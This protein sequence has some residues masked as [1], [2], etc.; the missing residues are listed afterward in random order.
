ML[1]RTQKDQP[2]RRPAQAGFLSPPPAAI[3]ET[4]VRFAWPA[5][6]RRRFR[7]KM[8]QNLA[9]RQV[10]PQRPTMRSPGDAVEK[11]PVVDLRLASGPTWVRNQHQVERRTAEPDRVLDPI[12][13]P[14][15][16]A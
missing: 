11:M 6:L 1:H 12:A 16:A 10:S 14:Q 2:V 8:S 9:S 15:P 7:D 13:G 4:P 5:S 3:R